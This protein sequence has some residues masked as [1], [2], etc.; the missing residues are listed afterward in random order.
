M[1][2]Q[3]FRSRSH[4]AF[5]CCALAICFLVTSCTTVTVSNAD[6]VKEHYLGLLILRVQPSQGSM[7]F[8]ETHGL[9]LTMGMHSTTLGFLSESAFLATDGSTCRA[10]MVITNGADASALEHLLQKNHYSQIC[11]IRKE[12]PWERKN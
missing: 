5:S 9:G 11:V 10:L 2:A 12:E 7:S 4:A 6:V 8:I 1:P 3:P